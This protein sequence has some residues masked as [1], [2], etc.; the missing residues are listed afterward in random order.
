[1]MASVLR[2]QFGYQIISGTCSN[3]FVTPDEPHQ[4]HNNG[5]DQK[6]VNEITHRVA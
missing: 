3:D 2:V 1:M 5:D 6:N 4:N